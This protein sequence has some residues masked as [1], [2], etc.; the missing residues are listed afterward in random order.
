MAMRDR[1]WLPLF[2]A[3]GVLVLAAHLVIGAWSVLMAARWL[4]WALALVVVTVAIAA[5]VLGLRRLTRRRRAA[6]ATDD[7]QSA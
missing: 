7:G 6:A 5:H 2:V 3:L 4:G 1:N